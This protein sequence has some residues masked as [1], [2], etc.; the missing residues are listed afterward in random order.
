MSPDVK[1]KFDELCRRLEAEMNAPPLVYASSPGALYDAASYRALVALG[2]EIAEACVERVRAGDWWLARA[3]MEVIGLSLR[4]LGVTDELVA[5]QDVA[6]A[7]LKWWDAA[8]VVTWVWTAWS[9]DYVSVKPEPLPSSGT[10]SQT[11]EHRKPPRAQPS[12]DPGT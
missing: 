5:E 4:E 12:A 6:T 11:V 7:L 10:T 8:P 3:A 1:A 2:A 9:P